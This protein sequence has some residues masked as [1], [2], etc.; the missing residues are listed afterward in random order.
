MKKKRAFCTI[1]DYCQPILSIFIWMSQRSDE[2]MQMVS[3]DERCHIFVQTLNLLAFILCL[4]DAMHSVRIVASMN[5]DCRGHAVIWYFFLFIQN[6][7]MTKFI[8]TN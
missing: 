1:N 4:A 2:I 3:I 8:F 5:S 7:Q 6:K